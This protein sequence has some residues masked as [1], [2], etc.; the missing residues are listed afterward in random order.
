MLSVLSSL[1]TLDHLQIEEIK[2]SFIITVLDIY[3]QFQIAVQKLAV[4]C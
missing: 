2:E 4:N 3:L 1:V